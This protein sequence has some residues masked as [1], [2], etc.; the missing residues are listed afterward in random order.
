[1]LAVLC[2]MSVQM[3][4]LMA[5]QDYS[6]EVVIYVEGNRIDL[7]NEIGK[8]GYNEISMT[9]ARVIYENGEGNRLVVKTPTTN[10]SDIICQLFPR[11]YKTI[12]VKNTYNN[13]DIYIDNIF[14][15][16]GRT[17]LGKTLVLV[18]QLNEGNHELRLERGD[19]I[20]R[21]VLSVEPA[22][23]AYLCEGKKTF[24]CRYY[25]VQK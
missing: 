16:R 13:A 21:T 23:E 9:A 18:E 10:I 5:K 17:K 12:N 24:S 19:V 1:M 14:T 22:D 8:R 6:G 3:N 4:E 20:A 11:G 7:N 15:P 2:M 25:E